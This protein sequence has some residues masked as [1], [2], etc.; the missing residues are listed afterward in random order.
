MSGWRATALVVVLAAVGAAGTLAVAAVQG[1]GGDLVDIAAY[2]V[3]ALLVTALATA[4]ARPLLVRASMHARLTAVATVG[5]AVA[6]VN[7][8]V[9]ARTMFVSNHDA[10]LVGVLLLYSLGA[11]AGAALV[12]ARISTAAVDRLAGTARALGEGDLDARVG[13]LEAGP[14]LRTLA[15]TL[16]EMARRLQTA[17]E[18]ERQVEAVRRD[19]VTAVSHDLRTPLSSLRAMVEAIDEGVVDDVPS[20]QRYAVEMRRS[21]NQLVA[22]VD[23]LFELVQLDAG[24]IEAETERA[25]LDEI[26][27]SALAT[28]ELQAEE[29]RLSLVSNLEAAAADAP[30]SPRL[31]RVLQNLLV[32]AVR[33]T[34]V[35][36]TVRLD[37]R[38]LPAGLE[39]TVEDT[40]EGIAPQH[41]GRV[42][43]PFFRADP[44]RSGPGAGLGLALARRIVEALGGRIEA[45]SEPAQGSRFAVLLPLG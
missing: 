4:I 18:R 12:V 8:F 30:C 34:P 31:A 42:F 7:L 15:G 23:D 10:T 19:L 3:P 29:K 26:V 44:S 25:R 40:G 38:R 41:L 36:G 14:E 1:M 13:E 43:E 5:A 22:M 39:L 24:A 17:Q 16:D 28:V 6:L 9:L 45:E 2:I 27:R 20:L 35:D 33:H 37:A 32:N 21:V 11:G